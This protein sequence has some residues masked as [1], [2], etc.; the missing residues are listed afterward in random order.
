MYRIAWLI[1]AVGCLNV[2]LFALEINTC[3]QK[4]V[5]RALSAKT[6]EKATLNIG[7][8]LR[9][10]QSANYFD[11][12]FLNSSFQ[13]IVS[14]DGI[15]VGD[16]G[17]ETARQFS[18]NIFFA[19]NA[20]RLMDLSC[21]LPIYY[22]WSGISNIRDGGLGDL[23]FS[24]KIN[25]PSATKIFYQGYLISG[26]LPLGTKKGGLFTRHSYLI[27]DK[28]INPAKSF[29]S[30]G[31]PTLTGLI[32]LTFDITKVQ[33]SIPLQIHANLGGSINA[34][35]IQQRNL[36]LGS[37]AAEFQALEYL[38]F[39]LDL[40]GETR[41]SNLSTTVVRLREDPI[42][43]SPG[44]KFQLPSGLYIFF[45]GDFSLSSRQRNARL[46]WQPEFGNARGY[47]YSTATQPLY[48]LQC[49][50]GWNGFMTTQDDDK[51]GI[52]NNL[53][54]C[55]AAPEDF[56]GFQDGD[57]CPDLDNDNDGVPDTKDK[58]PNISEDIDGFEDDD[59]CPD[60]D[61]D[62]DGIIDLNDKCPNVAEDID[63]FEDSDGCPD[64]D[65]DKDGISDT[66]DRCPDKMEDFDAFED[67]DG[68]PDLDNDKD[69]IPDLKDN[70]PNE[71]E[72]FNGYKDEDGCPDTVK[73]EADVPKQ[74]ILFG[75][76]FKTGS[77]EMTFD[78]YQSIDP[79]VKKLKQ[80]PE[81]EIE[82]RGHM[83]SAGDLA[84]NLQMTQM[85]AE[86]IR[87][88]L[89]S[90]GIEAS[91]VKAVGV[92]SASP[93]ADNRTAAGRAQNRRIEIVRLK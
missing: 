49:Q 61:N 16:S 8:G 21:N 37:L 28:D 83:D 32:L 51:D 4:G 72:T 34:S 75:V 89:I 66:L 13:P 53:D 73:K 44:L 38:S 30:A 52:N 92:G 35:K 17:K 78:S 11:G 68:C 39:F 67:D 45:N 18:S 64:Y 15:V 88:Y 5:V 65:N 70:C 87:Q 84:K 80:Y 33:P 82:V 1:I 19:V 41:M 7:A 58:C 36:I 77:P 14:S 22:D 93:I 40:S 74:Q 59:G 29:Y 26:T 47:K 91:R 71:P 24:V 23:R 55:P 3:G 2:H 57:G 81:V 56:D 43:L 50:I 69:G 9:F 10:S 63:G 31:S 12:Q 27:E 90:K 76:L 62:K 42:L 20:F 60:L 6:F 46:N 85:R 48:G 25:T 79:L 54:K 86:A